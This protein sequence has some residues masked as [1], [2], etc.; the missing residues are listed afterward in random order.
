MKKLMATLMAA[1]LVLAMAVPAFGA[2][3]TPSAEQKGSPRVVPRRSA[4]GTME[5]Y[6][7]FDAQGNEIA[8]DDTLK[9]VTTAYSE[10]NSALTEIKDILTKA[11]AKIDAASTPADLTGDVN[12]AAK[13]FSLA[14]DD[15]EI[16]EFFDASFVRNGDTYVPFGEVGETVKV[17]FRTSLGANDPLV[18]LVSCD[19][20]KWEVIED[21]KIADGAVDVTFDKFCAVVFLTEGNV[22]GS[23]N[24]PQTG[25]VTT[26][27]IVSVALVAALALCIGGSMI[28]DRKHS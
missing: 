2:I 27:I 28:V 17:S 10:R 25:D 3:I 15:L 6:L 23:G 5:D 24:S 19:G 12:D 11:K 13:K 8:P 21:A 16:T 22:S 26:G 14:A 7:A 18:V 4:A 20:D 1:M 9:L